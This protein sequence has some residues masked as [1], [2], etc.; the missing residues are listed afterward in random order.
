MKTLGRILIILTAFTVL[1][2][3]MVWV[4][5]VNGVN[6]PDFARNSGE[7]EFRPPQGNED[8]Q[9]GSRPP[10]EIGE[11]HEGREGRGSFGGRWVFSLIKNVG[12]I[13]V[14]VVAVVFPKSIIKK[15]R[16]TSVAPT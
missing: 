15:K 10:R 13:S 14:L 2:G 5:N 1:G 9:E 3:L 7:A 11:N 6:T 12:V 4:G 8:G 16:K